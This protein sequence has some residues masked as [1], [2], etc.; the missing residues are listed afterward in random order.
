M[1]GARHAPT[2]SKRVPCNLAS[3]TI[4]GAATAAHHSWMATGTTLLPQGMAKAR[5]EQSTMPPPYPA[6]PTYTQPSRSLSSFSCSL[7]ASYNHTPRPLL[8]FP[9]SSPH[10]LASLT[11][12]VLPLTRPIFLTVDK[13]NRRHYHLHPH[14]RFASLPPSKRISTFLHHDTSF[15]DQEHPFPPS[16]YSFRNSYRSTIT[17]GVLIWHLLPLVNTK[18]TISTVVSYSRTDST[19]RKSSA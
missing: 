8:A 2:S 5:K 1:V 10:L 14:N 17:I 4:A 11:E 3:S 9:I 19:P 15:L 6:E 12:S 13:N 18:A 16:D 7:L